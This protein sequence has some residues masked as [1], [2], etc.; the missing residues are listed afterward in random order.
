MNFI[1]KT[2]NKAYLRNSDRLQQTYKPGLRPP[3]CGI[4]RDTSVGETKRRFIVRTHEHLG[5]E[6]S[7]QI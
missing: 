3:L 1:D 6:Q 2:D 5:I 7:N 4:C